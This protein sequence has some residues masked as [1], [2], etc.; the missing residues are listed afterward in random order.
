MTLTTP[1]LRVSVC[2]YNSIASPDPLTPNHL[3]SF[4]PRQYEGADNNTIWH[5]L[6]TRHHGRQAP[7]GSRYLDYPSPFVLARTTLICE[8][9]CASKCWDNSKYVSTCVKANE[10][11]C[12]CEDA[13]FQSVCGPFM[14][15]SIYSALLINSRW[16]SNVSTLNARLLN[17][18]PL[19]TKPSWPALILGWTP[20][21]PCLLSF[22]TKL[23][24]NAEAQA[25][26][27]HQD[28]S[29]HQPFTP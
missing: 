20:S 6:A 22:V 27:M 7:R 14:S 28:I 25:L 5:W 3:Q 29:P 15:P 11:Q 2:R 1:S 26:A 23:Y 12:L 9:G 4:L 10:A 21:M 17:S 18:A 24:A 19:F 13:D 16:S 8:Q